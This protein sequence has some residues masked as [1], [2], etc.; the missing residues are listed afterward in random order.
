MP[1]FLAQRYDNRVKTVMALFWL[2]VYTFVNL[3]S[4]L[5]LG[6]LAINTCSGCRLGGGSCCPWC[7]LQLPTRFMEASGRSR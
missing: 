6:A 4:I 5:W 3:T 2:G 7:L 1:Q